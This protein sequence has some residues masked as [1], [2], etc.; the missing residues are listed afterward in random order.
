MTAARG[1]GLAALAITD[2]DT[3]SGIA[4]AV[5]AGAALGVRVIS[6]VEIS[7]TLSRGTLHVLGYGIDPTEP[8]LAAG[9]SRL[10]QARN[11]RNPLI[12]KRLNRL[13][14]SLTMAE[15]EAEAGGDLIGRPHIARALVRTGAVASI[16]DAFDRYL[17][18]EAAAYVD[19]FR[20]PPEEGLALI[21]GAGGLPVLAHPYQTRRRGEELRTLVATLRKQGLEGLEVYY[22]RHNA[23]QTAFY[24]QLAEAF[25]LVVTGGTDFHGEATP[26]IQLGTGRGE[27]FFIPAQLLESIDARL[28]QLRRSFES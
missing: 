25:D 11:A 2:H 17:G 4:E 15:V 9:L 19:K 26:H 3:T 27:G 18:S 14:V 13:G 28:E 12:L 5:A 24:R 10:H 21:R 22:P 20:L 1:A 7:C 23:E 8:R 16:Q 6:G